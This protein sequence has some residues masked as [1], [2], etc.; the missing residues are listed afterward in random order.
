M[1]VGLDEGVQC[2]LVSSEM[3]LHAKIASVM[4]RHDFASVG[5]WG[6]NMC[7][8]CIKP[9]YLII[10]VISFIPCLTP[11]KQFYWSRIDYCAVQ[12]YMGLITTWTSLVYLHNIISVS[13]LFH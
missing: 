1:R 3:K 10:Q 4:H 9:L 13:K 7:C 6:L 5:L 8:L 11:S 2:D 12:H